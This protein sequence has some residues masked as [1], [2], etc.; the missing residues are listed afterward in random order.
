MTAFKHTALVC[1]QEANADRFYQQLLGLE[2]AGPKVL[3]PSLAKAIFNIDAE[4]TII[5]YTGT[6]IHF[7]IFIAPG[8]PRNGQKIAHTCIEVDDRR[9]FL[10]ACRN[11]GISVNQVPRGEH[12]LLFVRDFDGNLFEVKSLKA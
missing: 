8:Q 12:V 7:E 10:D 11:L 3:P 2:K 1:S 9:L 6:G 5:N 4:L